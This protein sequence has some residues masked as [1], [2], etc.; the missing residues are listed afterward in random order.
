MELRY[1]MLYHL[2][3]VFLAHVCVIVDVL[4]II[5]SLPRKERSADD[6]RFC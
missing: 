5:L 1:V 4:G 2:V 6:A 3:L